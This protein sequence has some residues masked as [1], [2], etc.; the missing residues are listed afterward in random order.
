MPP[1]FQ[2]TFI[3]KGPI[4]S[5]STG[6]VQPVTRVR[7]ID[8]VSF[9]SKLIFGLSI[10]LALGVVGY[11]WYLNY[12]IE[13]MGVELEAAK[14]EISTGVVGELVNL[15]NRITSA[16]TL[17]KNH[18]ALSPLFTFLEASTPKAV[19]FTEFSYSKGEDGPEILLKG[20][21]TS[22]SALAFEADT[23]NENKDLKNPIFSDIR[24]DDKGNV[25]FSLKVQVAPDLVSYQKAINRT[26]VTTA[27]V[28]TPTATTTATTT[29]RTSTS[30]TPR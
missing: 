2:S 29:P 8:F 21:A 25:T 19:R 23:I 13:K 3:P 15:N 20:Q 14:Q 12:S 7:H 10:L 9:L 17:I 30:T 24:L 11:K 4:A 27:P 18:R 26:P 28:V 1:K 6:V 16:D 5:S 22:Y